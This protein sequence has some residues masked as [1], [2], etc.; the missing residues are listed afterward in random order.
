MGFKP[1]KEYRLV[2]KKSTASSSGNKKKGV[3][4]TIEVSN[5]NPFVVL[6][7]VNNN[8]EF[9]TNS[10]NTPTGEKIDKIERQ[11]CEGKLSV[12]I[13]RLHDDIRITTTQ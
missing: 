7:S 5:S 8:G 11:I 10:N 4:P 2:P 9:G 6:N 13:K 1:Q 12:G 3:E